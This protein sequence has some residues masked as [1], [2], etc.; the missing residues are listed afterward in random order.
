M[1]PVFILKYIEFCFLEFQ[2]SKAT[3]C[4]T[5]SKMIEYFINIC[6]PASLLG[7]IMTHF[8][9]PF[10]LNHGHILEMPFKEGILTILANEDMNCF[11][12]IDR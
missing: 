7:S 2:R 6:N 5:I 11:S 12:C 9:C 3:M 4:Q 1:I 8:I 10:V